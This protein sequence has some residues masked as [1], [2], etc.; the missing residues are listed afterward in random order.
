MAFWTYMLHCH[1]GQYYTAHSDDLENRM[2]QHHAG[3]IRG[4]T[5]DRLPVKLVW[6]QDFPTR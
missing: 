6:A 3:S 5:A 4:F 1:G 2:A